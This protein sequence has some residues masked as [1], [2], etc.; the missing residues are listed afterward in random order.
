M[1]S[2]DALRVDRRA[3][4]LPS[5][6]FQAR[7]W[8]LGK[9]IAAEHTYAN[10]T[11]ARRWLSTIEADIVRGRWVDPDA[12]KI[13]FGEYANWRIEQRPVRPRTKQIYE[14]R[15]KHI[16]VRR[17]IRDLCLSH[18]DSLSYWGGRSEAR[19]THLAALTV[20]Q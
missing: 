6:K 4:K 7:Y 8:H 16:P 11:D 2:H 13:T 12:G 19:R 15:L 5:G 9:Q 14:G 18:F 3:R 20:Q 10:K 1:S 17:H